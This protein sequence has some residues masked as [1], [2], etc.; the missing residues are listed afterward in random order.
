MAY[1][2]ASFVWYIIKTLSQV[3]SYIVMIVKNC[4]MQRIKKINLNII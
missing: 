2:Y 4:V 1:K 3:T